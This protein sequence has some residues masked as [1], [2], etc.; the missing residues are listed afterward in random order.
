MT[1]TD[2]ETFVDAAAQAADFPLTAEQR[3]GTLVNFAR[4]A[5]MAALVDGLACDETIEPAPVF[6]HD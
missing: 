1:D 5:A 4:I 3:P 6:R 2:I